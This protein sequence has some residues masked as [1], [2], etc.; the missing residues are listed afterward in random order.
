MGPVAASGWAVFAL[1]AGLA[2]LTSR[3]IG[4]ARSA[5]LARLLNGLGA[6]TMGLVAGPTALVVAY[7]ATYA[8]HGSAGPMHGALLH[9]QASAHNRATLLSMNSMTA[10]AGFALA[11]P[12]LG[13][14]T[15]S[16]SN[17][18]A[19]V[20]AGVISL[21]GALCYLP[22]LREEHFVRAAEPKPSR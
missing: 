4:V 9:R 21:A 14:M 13:L 6:V 5:I 8:I 16:T 7:L 12:L 3:R 10:S 18:T 2:G 1:G 15:V 19:M 22:A 11:A 20:T 17:Q